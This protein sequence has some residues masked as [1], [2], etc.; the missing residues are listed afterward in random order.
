MDPVLQRAM[1]QQQQQ[2]Q[3]AMTEADN[4][5]SAQGLQAVAQQMQ[6]VNTEIDNAEDVAGIM[7]AIRGDNATVEQRRAELAQE[8]G[9]ADANAT[10]ES[11]LVMLQPTFEMMESLTGQSPDMPMG[12]A[13]VETFTAE[14]T[15]ITSGLMPMPDEG[16]KKDNFRSEEAI[17]R[18]NAGET[19]VKARDGYSV[20]TNFLN[21]MMGANQNVAN[22]NSMLGNSNFRLNI[23]VNLPG[24]FD[25]KLAAEP[26]PVTMQDNQ[27]LLDANIEKVYGSFE[28]LLEN[29]RP[30]PD[31]DRFIAE[32]QLLLQPYLTKK[33]TPQENL[34]QLQSIYGDSD[35]GVPANLAIAKFGANIAK[36]TGTLP[37]AAFEAIPG[38]T[39]E[40][41]QI[42]LL[43][44][45]NQK[46]LR[47][48]AFELSTK[49]GVAR[50]KQIGDIAV[51]ALERV[52]KD[53]DTFNA[54][55]KDAIKTAIQQGR[56]FTEF[57]LNAVATRLKN[58]ATTNKE[59][60]KNAKKYGKFVDGKLTDVKMAY[61]TANPENPVQ[62]YDDKT[63]SFKPLLN[64][65]EVDDDA[66]SKAIGNGTWD[67]KNA[68]EGFVTYF[69]DDAPGDVQSR[70]R[71]VKTY[72]YPGGG[73]TWF[74]DPDNDG[75]WTSLHKVTNGN[76]QHGKMTDLVKITKA[77][78]A[79]DRY[80][81]DYV[82]PDARGN[83]SVRLVE[84]VYEDP[85]TGEIKKYVLP[86][87]TYR[88]NLPKYEIE[89]V[90]H[91]IS[92]KVTVKTLTNQN[93]NPT[94][95]EGVNLELNVEKLPPKTKALMMTQI[96]RYTDLIASIDKLLESSALESGI[97]VVPALKRGYNAVLPPILGFESYIKTGE[98]DVMIK[99]L[100][101][102]Y[103]LA[104]ALSDKFAIKEQEMLRDIFPGIEIFKSGDVT[105]AQI[106]TIR[107]QLVNDL[108]ERLAV[109]N[110]QQNIQAEKMPAGLN[111]E[112][113]IPLDYRGKNGQFGFNNMLKMQAGAGDDLNGVFVSTSKTSLI[114]NANDQLSRVA[115]A[116]N[117]VNSSTT[118]SQAEK[119]VEIKK[120]TD[121]A[122]NLNRVLNRLGNTTD[123]RIIMQINSSTRS[124]LGF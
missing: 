25:N 19:P 66:I 113:A 109:V 89:E 29:M 69:K 13:P 68:S 24:T 82:R 101:R 79:G 15:G 48:K 9:E 100:E 77:N 118:L 95:Y 98:G 28:P 81:I 120:F 44:R 46:D 20:G 3:Q 12:D 63:R 114:N 56:E 36:G 64:Y 119:D 8:V 10:P 86:Q 112:T 73:G 5:K 32:R 52:D 53:S 104:K 42:A 2:Q 11:V 116:I 65:V 106:M 108:N 85:N 1:F 110:N 83:A 103:I 87:N 74:E 92:G 33:L 71:T 62:Y 123:K 30:R 37:E 39:T 21:S 115:N 14:G 40:L 111:E 34:A 121:M 18:I 91:P 80:M 105:Q 94:A 22:N 17:A 124:L 59:V 70:Y 47:T 57:D 90:D 93:A 122:K 84:T 49:Q 41:S 50:D 54:G 38:L 67:K 117:Q 16:K 96:S 61:L 72:T 78:A 23:P 55:V 27:A 31:V 45:K 99:E 35:L 75:K 102:K 4:V 51:A 43:K 107:H 58:L 6:N 97:G 76:H 88:N 26:R 60:L 7:N